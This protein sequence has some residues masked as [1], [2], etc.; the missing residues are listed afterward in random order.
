M[1]RLYIL[2]ILAVIIPCYTAAVTRTVKVDGS[3]DYTSIQ[4]AIDAANPGDTVLVY[5][6]RYY[7]NLSI[8]TN[9]INLMSLEGTTGDPAYIDSTIVDGTDSIGGIIVGQFKIGINIRGFSITNGIGAGIALGASSESIVS[10]CKIFRRTSTYG[11]GVNIGGATVHLSGVDIY[12]NYAIFLGG[13]LY[14]SR[15]TGHTTNIIFDPV[16]RCSIYNNRSGSG[17]DIYI[18]HA[19]ED[20]YVPLN[21]FSVAEPSNYHAVYLSDDP[22]ISNYRIN[23]DILNAHHQEIDSDLYVSTIGD[24]ANDGLSPASALKTIHEAIYGI[25]A[26]SLY[27]NTVHILPGEYSRTDNDQ[28][29][30]IALKSWVKVQ[31]SGIDTTTVIGESHPQ[32]LDNLS[33]QIFSANQEE[34]VWLADLSITSRNINRYCIAIGGAIGKLSV[35][36]SNLRI[37]DIKAHETYSGMYNVIYTTLVSEPESIWD[38]VTIENISPAKVYLIK[39]LAGIPDIGEITAMKGKFSNCTFRNASSTYT[40]ASVMGIPLISIKGDKRLEFENCVF[41]NLSVED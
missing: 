7:E 12:D 26:D 30:P 22:L 28:I 20:L 19:T 24:D 34:A 6:G 32:P 14:S 8:Q 3:G 10:N 21:T 17:Q 5:P 33:T 29:F 25:A 40:S 39:N 18:Q 2:I 11:G 36:F 38:N 27:Q 4:A 23:F 1:N 41:E 15:P 37:Y 31:G 9:D 16:N 13:G 35:N